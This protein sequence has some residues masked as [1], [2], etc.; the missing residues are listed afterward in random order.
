MSV[1]EADDKKPRDD[2][3]NAIFSMMKKAE[4]TSGLDLLMRT[5]AFNKSLLMGL[6]EVGV[7]AGIEEYQSI[8]AMIYLLMSL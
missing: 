1:D 4:A 7:D 6:S 8:S 3:Y 2:L 5:D